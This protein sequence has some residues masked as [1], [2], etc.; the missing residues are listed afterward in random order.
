MS[1]LIKESLESLAGDVEVQKA[2]ERWI[3]ELVNKIAKMAVQQVRKDTEVSQMVVELQAIEEALRTA[4]KEQEWK[5]GELTTLLQTAQ[6]E[7]GEARKATT[8][9]QA[10]AT[11]LLFEG[12]GPQGSYKP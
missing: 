6:R 2:R 9:S 3:A 1:A 12:R 8:R 5:N 11:T 7:L 10:S 4:L